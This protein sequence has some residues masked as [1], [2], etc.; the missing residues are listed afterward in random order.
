MSVI[1]RYCDSMCDDH[2]IMSQ[3]LE[4][5]KRFPLVRDWSQFESVPR[6]FSVVSKEW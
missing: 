1:K 6:V 2:K 4:R 5:V 3:E